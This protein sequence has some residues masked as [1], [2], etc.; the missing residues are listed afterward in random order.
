M[1]TCN[2]SDLQTLGYRPVMPKNLP[3]HWNTYEPCSSRWTPYTFGQDG[4]A[5][6][7][8][9]IWWASGLHEN[10]LSHWLS[11]R[12]KGIGWGAGVEW[13]QRGAP[14]IPHRSLAEYLRIPSWRKQPAECGSR[15]RHVSRI[16]SPRLPLCDDL[17]PHWLQ[18]APRCL[19]LSGKHVG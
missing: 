15:V 7:H 13:V 10:S 12:V 6:S 9:R 14:R 8:T 4:F 18:V 2:R 1:S 19:P 3:G 17:H 16:G 5:V 11:S